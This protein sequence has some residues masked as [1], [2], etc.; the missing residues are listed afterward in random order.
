MTIVNIA[1]M[2][3]KQKEEEEESET[4]EKEGERDWRR[5]SF[6]IETLGGFVPKHQ[7]PGHS[8]QQNAGPP[9]QPPI[10]QMAFM[11]GMNTAIWNDATSANATSNGG[12]PAIWRIEST[13]RLTL[14]PHLAIQSMHLHHLHRLSKISKIESQLIIERVRVCIE[15]LIASASTAK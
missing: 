6:G 2:R 10:G 1:M 11:G 7:L 12:F 14:F 4:E 15:I 3:R 13:C 5:R 9:M 8:R